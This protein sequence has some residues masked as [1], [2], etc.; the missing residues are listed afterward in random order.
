MLSE[1]SKVISLNISI[2]HIKKE[3]CLLNNY[4]ECYLPENHIEYTS[5]SPSPPFFS[6][7]TNHMPVY[8]HSLLPFIFSCLFKIKMWS[9]LQ[10]MLLV[11]WLNCHPKWQEEIRRTVKC[12]KNDLNHLMKNLHGLVGIINNTMKRSTLNINLPISC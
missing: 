4:F 12:S 2:Y 1:N 5:I 9:F 10:V 11:F 6:F 3:L 7:C 8:L